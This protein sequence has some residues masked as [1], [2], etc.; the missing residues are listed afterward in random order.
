MESSKSIPDHF[1]LFS[2]VGRPKNDSFNVLFKVD[3][4]YNNYLHALK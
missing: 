4:K 3:I 1:G 2:L